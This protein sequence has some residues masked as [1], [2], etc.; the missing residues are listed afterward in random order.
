VRVDQVANVLDSGA[1][2]LS[3]LYVPGSQPQATRLA[4]MLAPKPATIAPIDPAV[5]AAAGSGAKLAVVIT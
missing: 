4:H 1:P 2:G 5:Q 3:I